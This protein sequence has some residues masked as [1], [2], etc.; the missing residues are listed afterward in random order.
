MTY[1]ENKGV[2]WTLAVLAVLAGL[3]A[4]FFLSSQ[5]F[6]LVVLFDR[7]G[8]LRK[9]DPVTWREFTIGKVEKIEPLVENRIGVTIRIRS[10]YADRISEGTRFTLIEPSFFGMIGNRGIAID[11]PPVPGK[12]LV[13]GARVAGYAPEK[14]SFVEDGRRWTLEQWRQI[15]DGT[16]DLLAEF[17]QSPWRKDAEEAL[18]ELKRAAAEGAQQT[19]DSLEEFRRNHQSDLDD[20]LRKLDRLREQMKRGKT[21]PKAEAPDPPRK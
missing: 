2:W 15:R 11:N 13:R 20:A 10:E 8:A 19:G 6:T 16:A 3:V 17:D 21:P 7:V 1:A 4:W 14:R 12:P 18:A 5:P 9:D